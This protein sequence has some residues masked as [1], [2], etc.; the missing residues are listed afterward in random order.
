[1]ALLDIRRANVAD[2][3]LLTE[4]GARTFRATYP[5]T[6]QQEL[7]EYIASSFTLPLV[8]ARLRD[9]QSSFWIATAAARVLGYAQLHRGDVPECVVGPAPIELA[10][11]YLEVSAQGSGY[12]FAMMTFLIAEARRLE[13]RTMWLGV[14]SE[15]TKAR[16]FYSSWGFSDVGTHGFEMAGKMYD[17][18]V[19]ARA[20]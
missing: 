10:R 8:T 11:L 14:Y 15:N 7:N 13:R 2:A 12:G 4:L 18:P 16:A 20:L 3:E 5:A 1:L 9:E 19:M 17:D 6:D